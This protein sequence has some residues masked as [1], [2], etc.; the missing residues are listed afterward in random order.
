MVYASKL[1]VTR[2]NI[3]TLL[4]IKVSFKKSSYCAYKFQQKGSSI[5][6]NW[7]LLW[8]TSTYSWSTYT[9]HLCII[10]TQGWQWHPGPCGVCKIVHKMKSGYWDKNLRD[11]KQQVGDLSFT[12]EMSW[13]TYKF[14]L[15][16]ENVGYNHKEN[17]C[18]RGS[19]KWKCNNVN[20]KIFTSFVNWYSSILNKITNDY[21][22]SYVE[23]HV[24]EFMSWIIKLNSVKTCVICQLN[25]S[26]GARF[27]NSWLALYSIA[28][29]MW[30][31]Y[32]IWWHSGQCRTPT[33]SLFRK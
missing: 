16:F 4:R 17:L 30:L 2:Y 24:A 12:S 14:E 15:M 29:V 11:K 6:I 23:S 5:V 33:S 7:V 27:I 26:Y 9:H 3:Y 22:N 25:P 8:K 1:V 21:N 28:Y 18:Y 20:C 31:Y 10:H 13:Q 19:T 32:S